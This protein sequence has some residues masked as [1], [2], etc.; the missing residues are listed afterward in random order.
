MQERAE[1]H[2]GEERGWVENSAG[3]AVEAFSN[4]FFRVLTNR[5]RPC[6]L[7]NCSQRRIS[8]RVTGSRTVGPSPSN[9]ESRERLEQLFDN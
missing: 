2:D 3:E 8:A 4:F 5:A 9:G 6:K 1:E 7:R